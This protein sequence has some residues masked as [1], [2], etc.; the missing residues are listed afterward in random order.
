MSIKG[1]KMKS[2]LIIFAMILTSEAM[3]VC[4]S[5]IARTNLGN[6]VLTATRYNTDL[7]TAYT[8]VNELPGDCITDE[9]ITSAKIDDGTIVN[10]D[11]SASAA[12][13]MSKVAFKAAVIN[14]T[15]TSGADAG[16]FASGSWTKRVLNTEQSDIDG[17][18]SIA[19]DVF[20]LQAG[21]YFI[22][23]SAPAYAV[24]EHQIKLRNTSSSSDAILGTVEDADAA[25]L[26]QNRSTLSGVLVLV[27]ATTFEL[28]HQCETTNTGDGLGKG[29]S[30]GSFGVSG[31]F[32]IVEITKIK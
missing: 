18:V 16:D 30:L 2:M 5:P 20:T 8:R 1:L 24:G 9:T 6:V 13:E 17:I 25:N 3:A 26:V 21:T 4:S 28:Q 22:R 23:A 15:L 32:S 12:I 31:V 10:A 29:V 14:G 27:A 19:S 11:I 7:N